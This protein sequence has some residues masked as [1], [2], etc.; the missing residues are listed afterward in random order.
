MIE[1][2]LENIAKRGYSVVWRYNPFGDEIVIAMTKKVGDKTYKK[3]GTLRNPD[4][5]HIGGF[6]L[7]MIMQLQYMASEMDRETPNQDEIDHLKRAIGRLQMDP[8]R[9]F[10][11]SNYIKED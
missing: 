1:Q 11:I 2:A 10:S 7:A 4:L 6:E 5:G 8:I 3:E 9:I